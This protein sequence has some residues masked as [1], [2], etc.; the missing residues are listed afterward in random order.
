MGG[1]HQKLR[2]NDLENSVR[3]LLHLVTYHIKYMRLSV[4]VTQFLFF[5]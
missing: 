4:G 3:T 1:N 2:G 5:I